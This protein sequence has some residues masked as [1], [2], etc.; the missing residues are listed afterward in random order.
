E[1]WWLRWKC[2]RFR[3]TTWT[4]SKSRTCACWL[5]NWDAVF[6]AQAVSL[7]LPANEKMQELGNRRPIKSVFAANVTADALQTESGSTSIG[8]LQNGAALPFVIQG[9]KTL[10]L[11]AWADANR[12]FIETKLLKAGA[13]LFR[14]F[15]FLTIDEFEQL[16]ETVSGPL[17]DYSYRST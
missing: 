4:S 17:L 3:V 10:D 14:N 2:T 12:D 1:N 15:S 7:R 9:N 16:V 8:Y 5:R 13:I 11:I 6:V